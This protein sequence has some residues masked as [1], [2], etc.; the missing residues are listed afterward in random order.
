MLADQ[1]DRKGGSE[2]GSEGEPLGVLL[3]LRG[4]A[5]GWGGQDAG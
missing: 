1:L 3:L 2:S 4:V 5:L